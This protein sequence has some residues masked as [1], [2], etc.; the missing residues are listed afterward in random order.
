MRNVPN[1]SGLRRV[2]SAALWLPSNRIFKRGFPL[3]PMQARFGYN[4]R[5]Y[6]VLNISEGDFSERFRVSRSRKRLPHPSER[7]RILKKLDRLDFIH[8]MEFTKSSLNFY[9]TVRKSNYKS[10]T[11][12]FAGCLDL[13]ESGMSLY[14]SEMLVNDVVVSTVI[15][16]AYNDCLYYIVPASQNSKYSYGILH[17]LELV[18]LAYKENFKY[19]SALVS[20]G[21]TSYKKNIFLDSYEVL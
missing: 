18:D 2:D 5:I 16:G 8:W 14:V 12:K 19:V 4:R 15:Y 21:I 10:A 3:F 9:D 6:W 7:R 20:K 17:L 11:E 13:I 1:I